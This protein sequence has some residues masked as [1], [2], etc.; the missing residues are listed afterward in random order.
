MEAKAYLHL[1]VFFLTGSHATASSTTCS[2]YGSCARTTEWVSYM[3]SR[4]AKRAIARCSKGIC[5]NSGYN[6]SSNRDDRQTLL[7]TSEIKGISGGVYSAH[8][9]L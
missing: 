4:F 6:H 8:G 1:G 7:S 2:G 9:L 5:L 3:L